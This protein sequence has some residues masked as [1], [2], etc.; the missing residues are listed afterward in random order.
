MIDNQQSEPIVQH[1]I[2]HA[3]KCILK[4]LNTKDNRRIPELHYDWVFRYV[5]FFLMIT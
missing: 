4:G 3:R 1:F 2:I 5:S